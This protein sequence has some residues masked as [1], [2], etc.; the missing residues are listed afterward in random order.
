MS[1][2]SKC[3]KLC[4]L[5]ASKCQKLCQLKASK[6]QKL[7]QLKASK[8]QKLCQL[9]A[10]KCQK[11]CHLRPSKCQKLCHLTPSKC[12]KL[13]QNKSLFI[14]TSILNVIFRSL[15]CFPVLFPRCVCPLCLPVVLLPLCLPV[16]TPP[17]C[18]IRM[19]RGTRDPNFRCASPP[20]H[21][22]A[23]A[24]VERRKHWLEDFDP[25]I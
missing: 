2:A 3:Q 25:K 10:S 15:F 12:Q 16:V 22:R 1:V 4:Q 11:L 8:C 19:Q 7:C 17:L 14:F 13:Y 20:F 23:R 18:L 21:Q 5:K 9:K 6:C 24:L